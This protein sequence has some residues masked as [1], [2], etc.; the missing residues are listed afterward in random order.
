MDRGKE[1]RERGDRERSSKEH[2]NSTASPE[3]PE[4]LGKPKSYGVGAT[5]CGS[6]GLLNYVQ[7][8]IRPCDH[9]LPQPALPQPALPPAGPGLLP[10]LS[11]KSTHLPIWGLSRAP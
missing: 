9:G 1:R 7:L 11:V 5:L 2:G 3:D 10:L 8:R 4:A 6:L